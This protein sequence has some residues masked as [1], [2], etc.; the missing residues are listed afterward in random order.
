L[1]V[2]APLSRHKRDC[3]HG[4]CAPKSESYARNFVKLAFLLRGLLVLHVCYLSVV[5]IL[6]M[7][8]EA[9]ETCRG[10][11]IYDKVYITDAYSLHC[12]IVYIFFNVRIWSI[13]VVVLSYFFDP[14]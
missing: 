12:Y 10:I 4:N 5:C 14:I 8:A 2:H 3:L 6:M 7:V 1:S 11:V 13:V 9:T